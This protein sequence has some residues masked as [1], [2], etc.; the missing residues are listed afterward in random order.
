MKYI[1]YLTTNLINNKIYIGVH[2]TL[3]VDSFDGYLGCGVWSTK[4]STY[5][6]PK[7]AFQYAVKKYGVKNFKRYILYIFTSSEEA[8][9]KE[10][11]LV[12]EHF[13]KQPNN[14]NMVIGGKCGVLNNL[15]LYQFDTQGKLIKKWTTTYEA[16]CFFNTTINSFY[17]SL[18][19]KEKL[20]NCFWA[21]TSEINIEEYSHGDAKKRVYKYDAYTG[22]CLQEYNSIYEAAKLENINRSHLTNSIQMESKVND[23]Y[24]FST[25]LYDEFIVSP[26]KSLRNRHFYLYTLSG[27][28][29]KEFSSGKELLKYLNLHS[30][31]IIYRAIHSQNGIYKDYQIKLEFCGNQIEAGI[32]KSKAKKVSVYTIAGDF[33]KTCDS[34]QKAA[35]EFNTTTSS[36]NRVL[37]GLAN[38]A[39]NYI[40]RLVN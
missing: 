24:Y 12:T 4:P 5:M 32:V 21:R 35:N 7:T 29:L 15:P 27:N 23:Q 1:V 2:Q 9:Q 37:R 6:H 8:Y 13:I 17:T 3:N 28:F 30:W 33:I 38:T 26:K 40:F 18:Q 20:F 11:E 34:I 22:K 31:N 36:I 10:K 16:A 25:K 19:F 39:N 14:Y